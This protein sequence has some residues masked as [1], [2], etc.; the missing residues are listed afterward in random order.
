LLSRDIDPSFVIGQRLNL[1]DAPTAYETF[2]RQ[3]D[4]CATVVL[5]P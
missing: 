2:L 4:E 1:S 3:K 5:E